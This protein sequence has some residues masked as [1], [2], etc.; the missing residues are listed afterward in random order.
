MELSNSSGERKVVIAIYNIT[1]A[2]VT[3]NTTNNN[4]ASN[5]SPRNKEIVL[6][7]KNVGKGVV[8]FIA[9]INL[10]ICN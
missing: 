5:H 6:G 8:G 2:T 10:R 4:N 3:T 7:K 9:S 1:A